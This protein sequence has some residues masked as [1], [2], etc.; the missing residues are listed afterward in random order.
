MGILPKTHYFYKLKENKMEFKT[1][2]EKAENDLLLE[3]FYF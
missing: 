2:D 3:R 1:L